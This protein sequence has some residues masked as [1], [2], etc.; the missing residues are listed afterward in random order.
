LRCIAGFER[1]DRG[2]IL[3]DG[4]VIADG[5]SGVSVPPNK[6]HFGMV[7]QS[8]AI[9][10]HM[11]VLENVSYPL[12]VRGGLSR[13]E[14]RQRALAKLE[15]V[16]LAGLEARYPGQM[17]GGQQQRVALARAI[18]M[19]PRAL[20]LDEP[21]S[22]LDAKLRERMRFELVE[23]QRRLGV[24][25]VYVTHDQTEAMVMSSKVI[26]MNE[27]R[28]AQLGAPEGIY[29]RPADRFVADFIGS[30]NFFDAEVKAV[31]APGRYR[32][33]CALGDLDGTGDEMLS[34]GAPVL[35][36]IRPERVLIARDGAGGNVV[37]GKLRQRYFLGAR[38]EYVLDVDGATLRADMLSADVMPSDTPVR[39]RI[40]A[41]DCKIIPRR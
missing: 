39:A 27:G 5:A 2:C 40:A 18:V 33:A 4:E 22:N 26:V 29:E 34:V 9:W 38:C 31:T 28:I 6:R 32:I 8:Y 21:L 19:E 20:L 36:L 7:F 12:K 41:D 13:A 17:S 30:C 37:T 24:P 15:M 3:L 16:G 11:T 10:P 25:A 23:I 1:P 14:I 35:L